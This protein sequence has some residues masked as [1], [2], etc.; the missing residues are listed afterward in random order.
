MT[1]HDVDID[2]EPDGKH[3]CRQRPTSRTL[4]PHAG[5]SLLAPLPDDSQALQAFKVLVTASDSILTFPT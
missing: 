1:E 3:V 5:N 4:R 2:D